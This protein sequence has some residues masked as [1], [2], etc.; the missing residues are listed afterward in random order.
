MLKSYFNF[1]SEVKSYNPASDSTL[2]TTGK[3]RKR[4]ETVDT[5]ET[6]GDL[7]EGMFLLHCSP[8]IIHLRYVQK[9]LK[10]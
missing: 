3:K 1:C 9:C 8:S 2:P 7:S 10:N 6:N 5:E 4:E